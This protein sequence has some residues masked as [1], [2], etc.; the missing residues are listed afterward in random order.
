MHDRQATAVASMKHFI[1]HVCLFCLHG[2]LCITYMTG[3][4]GGQKRVSDFLEL[5]LL[6][7]ASCQLSAGN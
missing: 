2:C 7:A 1:L 4:G 6:M 3:A 5:D